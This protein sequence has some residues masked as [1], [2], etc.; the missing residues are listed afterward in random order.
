MKACSPFYCLLLFKHK[1][2]NK[3]VGCIQQ[4]KLNCGKGCYILPN[5]NLKKGQHYMESW[6]EDAELKQHFE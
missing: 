6:D 1:L 4:Y 5:E 3:A 2:S